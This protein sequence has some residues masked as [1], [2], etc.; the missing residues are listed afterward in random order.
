MELI[1]QLQNQG[2]RITSQR[3]KIVRCLYDAPL[4]V[5]EI[6]VKLKKN[7]EDVDLVSIYRTI[8]LLVKL[9]L[10]QTVDFGEGKKRYELTSTRDHH[11]HLV[12][13]SC[14]E[15]QDVSLPFEKQLFAKI[16][17]NSKFKV[18]HHVAEFFGTCVDCQ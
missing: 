13:N 2:Y 4:T 12:C 3:Q 7:G 15:V 18:N 16:A 10:V 1:T 17:K 14:K 5:E 9:K 6:A 11:H 8:K